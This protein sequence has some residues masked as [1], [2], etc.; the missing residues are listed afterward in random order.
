M[1]VVK[2]ALE[3]TCKEP[4]MVILSTPIVMKETMI[5]W[6]HHTL[7][8]KVEDMDNTIKWIVLKIMDP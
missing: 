4:Y 3:L 6:I 7:V 8:K 2:R 5:L 1:W